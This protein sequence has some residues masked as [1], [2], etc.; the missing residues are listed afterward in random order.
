[1]VGSVTAQRGDPDWRN[2]KENQRDP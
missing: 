2:Q 1:V